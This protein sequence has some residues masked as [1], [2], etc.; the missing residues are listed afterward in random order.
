MSADSISDFPDRLSPMLVKELR[1]GLRAKTFVAIFLSLQAMMALILFSASVGA[2]SA[3]A[4]GVISNIIFNFFAI[5]VLVVQPLRGISAISSEVKGNTIDMMVLTRLNASR[6][7]QGKWF[8]LV[9]Q[10]AL[11]LAT[12]F[13]Y[14]I[15]R[16]FFGGMNLFGEIMLLVLMFLT[17]MALTGITVGLSASSSV[18]VRALLPIIG[19]PFLFFTMVFGFAR[20]SGGVRPLAEVCSMNTQ[21]SAVAVAVFVAA[22]I[23]LGWSALSLGASLIAP[24]GENHATFRR[25][26]VLGMALATLV[27]S[28]TGSFDE[29]YLPVLLVVIC[30]PAIST[31][32]SEPAPNPTALDAPATGASALRRLTGWF[33][34][35]GWPAGV[36]FTLLLGLIFVLPV[37]GLLPSSV[38]YN[39]EF[40]ASIVAVIGALLFPGIIVI[41]ARVQGTG[42]IAAYLLILASSVVFMFITWLLS[43]AINEDNLLWFFIWNPSTFLPL[44]E[45]MPSSV[46]SVPLASFAVTALYGGILAIAALA[47]LRRQKD[48]AFIP[49]IQNT[50]P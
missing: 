31:A 48:G 1:Q 12:I 32:L 17:S 41:M 4:G 11:L 46:E 21:D 35:P 3:T 14:L 24:A 47:A 20:R 44:S 30:L 29:S 9:S 8:A 13:P 37:T 5:A 6:I 23:Y 34:D 10:S 50:R 15:L 18:I 22:A 36:F 19:L 40:Q 43:D 26:V 16:Y 49:A 2:S 25:L 7:I 42:R 27:F 39:D 28:M 45:E 33:L 38:V